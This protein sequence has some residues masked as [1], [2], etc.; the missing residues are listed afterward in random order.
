MEMAATEEAHL[1]YGLL[2]VDRVDNANH[3]C[4]WERPTQTPIRLLL[5]LSTSV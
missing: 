1:F 4:L 3:I 2:V 5:E